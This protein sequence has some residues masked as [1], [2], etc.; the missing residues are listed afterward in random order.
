MKKPDPSD[1]ARKKRRKNKIERN[2]RKRKKMLHNRKNS[3]GHKRSPRKRSKSQILKDI[4]ELSDKN[5]HQKEIINY[6][7]QNIRASVGGRAKSTIRRNKREIRFPERFSFIES[8]DEAIDTLYE[9]VDAF[10]SDV[11]GTIDLDQDRC[12]TIDYG[13][14]AVASILAKAA[15]DAYGLRLRGRYPEKQSL[16]EAVI[17]AGLPQH[18]GVD[19]PSLPHF[20]PFELHHGRPNDD[21]WGHRSSEK[22]VVTTEFIE[23]I[24][25][26]LSQHGYQLTRDGGKYIAGLSGEIIGNCEDHAGR[27]DWWIGG[28]MR[29]PR[30]GNVGD[31]HICIVNFGNTISDTIREMPKESKTYISVRNLIQKH[32]RSGS[33]PIVGNNFG[34]D[35]LWTLYALQQ[36]V[37]RFRSSNKEG[38]N[39]RG[40]G[41]T[42][43]IRFFQ[44]LGQTNKM[45][46]SPKMCVLSGS[47]HILFDG[48]YRMEQEYLGDRSRE[49]I[50]FNDE[51]DL[52]KP[53][54]P[55][56]VKALSGHFPGTVIS[57][58]FYLD[59]EH[60]MQNA[61]DN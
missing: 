12:E 37:S 28:Y 36:G 59:R 48:E 42:Q 34:E 45:G 18:L 38:E 15:S 31:C 14:E 16:K 1:K 27:D 44:D 39:D 49:I 57:M 58:K 61:N 50:A 17:A 46:A 43:M 32:C 8:P 10:N 3:R 9:M 26:C 20:N 7:N 4:S 47:T 19:L 5:K 54:D 11:R 24:D 55:D 25:R 35:Q 23:Y 30:N 40:Q 56:K 52:E 2:R 33:I 60:L 41:T 51:N 21:Q 22:E 13:A 53:P 6:V 29:M